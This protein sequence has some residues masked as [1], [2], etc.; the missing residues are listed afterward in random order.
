M[1][2]KAWDSTSIVESMKK[3][4]EIDMNNERKIELY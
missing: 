1:N 2:H 3:S 4:F